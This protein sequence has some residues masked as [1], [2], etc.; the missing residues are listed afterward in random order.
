MS[1]EVLET[2]PVAVSVV[3]VGISLAAFL[4]TRRTWFET[5]RPIVTA[6]IRTHDGGNEAIAFNL[7]VHNVGNRPATGIRL[8]VS[9]SALESL[10]DPN[11]R[12]RFKDEIERCFSEYGRISVL[13]P[14]ETV[15]N[16]F[17]VSSNNQSQNVLNYGSTAAIDIEYKDLNRRKYRSRI[18]LIVRDSAYFAGSGWSTPGA[19]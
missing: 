4:F 14:G 18:T 15:K 2:V 3:A 8:H 6:E 1:G 16:G 19:P 9:P 5:Y 7:A 10:V 13:H 11:A 12:D 17:G